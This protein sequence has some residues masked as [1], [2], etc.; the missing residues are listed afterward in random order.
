MRVLGIMSGTSI[1]GVDY[2]VCE[3]SSPAKIKFRDH[4][5]IPFPKSLKEQLHRA[6]RNETTTY[7]LADLH[8]DLG[9]FYAKGAG[10]LR[11]NLVGLHG[12]TVFHHPAKATLQIGEPAYLSEQLRIP[13]ISNFRAADIAAGGQGAPL[14]TIFH[15][16]VFAERG[17]HV[18]VN[19]L[20]GISNVTSLDWRTGKE[21]RLLAFDT[22][23]G[24]VL[25][26]LAAREFFKVPFDKDGKIAAR[27]K[28]NATV[29]ARWLEHDYFAQEPP[30]STG[31]ELFGETFFRQLR[32]SRPRLKP[33]DLLA[34]LT[35]LTV[36]SISYS[37]A[38]HLASFPDRVVLC[39]GGSRNSHLVIELQRTLKLF[40]PDTTVTTSAEYGWD[41]QVIE[42]SAFALLAW[43]TWHKQPGNLPTTTGAKGP[44]LL[45]QISGSPSL[46]APPRPLR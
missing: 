9:R 6:A 21:P 28:V 17:K 32:K 19:N 18:A 34:S 38:L 10:K 43:L 41:P 46:S 16:H 39:G 36:A 27:G 4:W 14:A 23:P 7:Q 37:Y 45:G 24:N 3:I 35:K 11:V 25:I 1:D 15:R 26:D 30:K 33:A 13:V 12:Q 42:A 29:V 44:R 2:A 40:Q 5:S 31:R 8:H 20:G 22:G